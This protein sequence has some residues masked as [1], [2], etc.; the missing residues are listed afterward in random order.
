VTKLIVTF[1]NFANMPENYEKPV[2]KIN[3]M[4]MSHIKARA[5]P[6]NPT[7]SV[8]RYHNKFLVLMLFHDPLLNH[9]VTMNDRLTQY[10]VQ[11]ATLME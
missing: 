9:A 3:I 4:N 10:T 1:H 11:R 8:E 6:L 5:L 7:C 2:R